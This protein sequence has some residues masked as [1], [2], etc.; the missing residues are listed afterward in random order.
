MILLARMQQKNGTAAEWLAEDPVLF[1]G[2]IGYETDTGRF[3]IGDGVSLWSALSYYTAVPP[4]YI[5]DVAGLALA[6][7]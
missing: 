1:A 5:G 3:K 7:G 2:E 4:L 6:L